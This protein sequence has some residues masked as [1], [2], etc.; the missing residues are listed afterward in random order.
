MDILIPLTP[1]AGG[2]H[3]AA[4][5][6]PDPAR[7]AVVDNIA[8]KLEPS[9]AEAPSGHGR[10]GDRARCYVS[11]QGFRR[12][13]LRSILSATGQS[14][15]E[16]AREGHKAAAQNEAFIAAYRDAYND[17]RRADRY[18]RREQARVDNMAG[19]WQHERGTLQAL[20]TGVR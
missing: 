7:R 14:I 19:R 12:A 3:F 9:P 13:T 1:E 5:L 20:R 16:W 18:E 17:A 6:A 2:E 10:L 11:R 15:P 4:L 8:C